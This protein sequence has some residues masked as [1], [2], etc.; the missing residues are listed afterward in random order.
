MTL[1]DVRQLDEAL[2]AR[3]EALSANKIVAHLGG[4][5]R[6]VLPLL[7]QYRAE[8][9]P[10]APGPPP[11]PVP[12][13]AAAPPPLLAQ[14]EQRLHAAETA[15]RAACRAVEDPHSGVTWDAVA[16]AQR[17]TRQ[18]Q[19]QLDRVRHG[20]GQIDRM[21]PDVERDLVQAE[22]ALASVVETAKKTIAKAQQRVS[23]VR[24]ECAR[25]VQQRVMIAGAQAVPVETLL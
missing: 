23:Q 6:D 14:A 15:A 16:Q 8:T 11:A 21:L 20:L 3:G 5:K 12:V 25:L 22:A 4:S 10:P 18:A 13:A 2:Q 24:E 19:A 9:P 17:R 7:R 1:D